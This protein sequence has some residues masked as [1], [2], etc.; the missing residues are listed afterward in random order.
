MDAIVPV[1]QNFLRRKFADIPPEVLRETKKSILD[2]LAA[3]VAGT[4]APG[5]P[6]IIAQVCEWGGKG[7]STI[8]NYQRKVPVFLA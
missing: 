7:E 2:T 8:L 4:K 6:E 1:V 5:C 3:L